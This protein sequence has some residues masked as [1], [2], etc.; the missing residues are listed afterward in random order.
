MSTGLA[1]FLFIAIVVAAAIHWR[2]R[3][4]FVAC[5]VAGVAGPVVFA[6]V[7]VFHG[8]QVFLPSFKVFLL[9]TILSLLIAA[10]VGLAF[11]TS[12]RLNHHRC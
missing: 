11:L 4:Y 10:V 7:S 9:F 6:A 1:V 2:L 5:A 12:R 8:E 3:K